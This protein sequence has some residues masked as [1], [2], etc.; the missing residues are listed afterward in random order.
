MTEVKELKIPFQEIS[1]I[2][3]ECGNP[4]CK[5]ELTIDVAP[6]KDWRGSDLVCVAC[7]TT[8]GNHLNGLI[9]DLI[10]A[11]KTVADAKVFFRV[12]LS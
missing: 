6:W 2:S 5:A 1:R 7:G 10:S 11:R 4:Q 8:L 12:R 9:K 3:I